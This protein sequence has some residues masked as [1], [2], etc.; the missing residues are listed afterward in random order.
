MPDSASLPGSR[1]GSRDGGGMRP[2]SREGI[3]KP[4]SFGSRPTSRGSVGVDGAGE[5]PT[6]RGSVTIDDRPNSRGGLDFSAGLDGLWAAAE[7]EEEDASIAFPS[8]DHQEGNPFPERPQSGLSSASGASSSQLSDDAEEVEQLI[9]SE[10]TAAAAAA[11]GSRST[12]TAPPQVAL[13]SDSDSL[14]LKGLEVGTGSAKTALMTCFL[15]CF[16]TFKGDFRCVL[17]K[18]TLL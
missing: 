2:S 4:S 8:A 7:E 5:R 9:D 11:A 10:L 6:S 3:L 16:C 17:G 12:A 15:Y 14:G 18:L 13:D 1:Q